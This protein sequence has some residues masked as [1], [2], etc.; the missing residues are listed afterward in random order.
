ME[1]PN[2]QAIPVGYQLQDYEIRKVLSAGGFSFVYIAHDKDKKLSP[3]KEYLPITLARNGEISRAIFKSK[4]QKNKLAVSTVAVPLG[5]TTTIMNPAVHQQTMRNDQCDGNAQTAKDLTDDE[6]EKAI[7]E[8]QA[9]IN[10]AQ[11]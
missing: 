10:K 3:S 5:A 1:A 6:I 4:R 2:S 8:I 7:A 9:A 11:I